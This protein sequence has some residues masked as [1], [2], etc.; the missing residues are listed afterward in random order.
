M[1]RSQM[2]RSLPRTITTDRRTAEKGHEREM[3]MKEATIITSMTSNP[4]PSIRP[5]KTIFSLIVFAGTF[6]LGA[7]PDSQARQCSNASLKG[8]YGFLDAHL[9]LPS[10]TPFTAIGL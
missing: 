1:T 9:V 4:E 8:A 5:K 3:S 6:A 7:A 2:L 10:A